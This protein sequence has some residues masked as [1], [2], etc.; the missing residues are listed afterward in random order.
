MTVTELTRGRQVLITVWG[1]LAG[2]MG[3]RDVKLILETGA[4]ERV[5]L[6]GGAGGCRRATVQA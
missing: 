6:A 2:P 1:A 5:P 3:E 4:V